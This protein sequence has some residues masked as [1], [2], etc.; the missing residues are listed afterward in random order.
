MLLNVLAGRIAGGEVQGSILLNGR[1][2]DKS[3]WRKT[4]GYVEQDDLMYQNLTVEETLHYAA[5]LRLPE[6]MSWD[7][8]KRLVDQVVSVLSLRK[9]LKTR[10]GDS[11]NRGIS[12][13]LPCSYKDIYANFTQVGSVSEYRLQWN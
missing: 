1:T 3:S 12:G 8:K 2:R 9:C 7:K 10:I 4:I 6:S 13:T 5:K 11:E